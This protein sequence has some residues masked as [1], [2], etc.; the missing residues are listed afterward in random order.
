M[1][2]RHDFD[3]VVIGAGAAGLAAAA[4][5]GSSPASVLVIEARE[6]SGGRGWTAIRDGYPLDL[7]CFWLHAAERNPWARIAEGFGFTVVRKRAPW[8]QQA[9]DTYFSREEQQAFYAESAA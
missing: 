1:N 4:T 5:L 3:V 8:G 9:L 2:E 7:G 6:R